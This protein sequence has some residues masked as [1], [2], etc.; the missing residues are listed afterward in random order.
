MGNANWPYRDIF[1]RILSRSWWDI[2]A[3]LVEA[4]TAILLLVDGVEVNPG[5]PKN[6]S[7]GVQDPLW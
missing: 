1:S 4:V 6:I 5:P 2:S 3:V 7:D